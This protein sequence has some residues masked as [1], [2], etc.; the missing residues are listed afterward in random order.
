MVIYV[1]DE[2]LY[3]KSELKKRGYNIINSKSEI[4]CDAIICNLK[5]TGFIKNNLQSNV[6]NE[7]TLVIDCGSKT[8][9]EIEYIINNRVYS[10][11]F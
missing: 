4:P 11:L 3:I 7:G 9:D 5:K 6:K 10:S 1:D 2:L 8:V